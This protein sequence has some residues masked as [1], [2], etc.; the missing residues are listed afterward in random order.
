MLKLYIYVISCA[1]ANI[2][3]LFQLLRACFGP[4]ILEIFFF[5]SKGPNRSPTYYIYV[6]DAYA[7]VKISVSTQ[8]GFQ[9]PNFCFKEILPP[10]PLTKQ[11]DPSRV[12]ESFRFVSMRRYDRILPLYHVIGLFVSR[13]STMDFLLSDMAHGENMFFAL[14]QFGQTGQGMMLHL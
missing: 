13:F 12:R 5:A 6:F 8:K 9:N 10:W 7:M 2:S 1:S 11:K 3:S 4:K 14:S